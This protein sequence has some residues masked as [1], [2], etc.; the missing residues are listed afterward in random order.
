MSMRTRPESIVERFYSNPSMSG[1]GRRIEVHDGSGR[2]TGDLICLVLEAAMAFRGQRVRCTGILPGVTM[3]VISEQLDPLD[4]GEKYEFID[5]IWDALRPTL[6]IWIK[7]TKPKSHMAMQ[8]TSGVSIDFYWKDASPVRSAFFEIVVHYEDGHLEKFAASRRRSPLLEKPT[9]ASRL[10][11]QRCLQ[12]RRLLLDALDK[13]RSTQDPR[14]R[15]VP[16]PVRFR[17]SGALAAWQQLRGTF[18]GQLIRTPLETHLASSPIGQ[19]MARMR[20]LV[21]SLLPNGLR[22]VSQDGLDVQVARSAVWQAFEMR[23]GSFY[24][25]SWPLHRIIE[26]AHI[27]DTV[28]VGMISLPADTLCILPKGES[29]TAGN[30]LIVIF[31]TDQG[32]DFLAWHQSAPEADAGRHEFSLLSFGHDAPGLTICEALD[33]AFSSSDLASDERRKQQERWRGTL[34]YAIK[35]LL[36]LKARDADVVADRAYTDAPRDFAGLG[37]RRRAER[38]EEIEQLYDRFIVGPAVVDRSLAEQLP[39]KGHGGQVPTHWRGPYFKM[40]HYGARNAHRRLLFVG[41]A[42]VRADRLGE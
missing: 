24:E 13:S 19:A 21:R 4:S 30:E 35:L 5:A 14:Y 2:D 25:P 20:A 3:Y 18:D 42:L 38:L 41:P 37:R 6:V 39:S 33:R 40:Q 8:L 1:G 29:A 26:T 31:R 11:R 34:D 22:G 28:P 32:L 15:H 10:L 9:D 36:Y 17:L 7:E 23:N 16:I 27:A 12:I